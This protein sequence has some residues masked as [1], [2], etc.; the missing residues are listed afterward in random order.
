[1]RAHPI[2]VFLAGAAA[3][4]ALQHFG[5]VGVSGKGKAA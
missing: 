4:W 1:M 5:G 3:Y 2:L